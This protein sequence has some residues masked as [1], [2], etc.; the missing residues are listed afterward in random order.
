MFAASNVE[1]C[2]TMYNSNLDARTS[3]IIYRILQIHNDTYTFID[4]TSFLL[5]L[6]QGEHGNLDSPQNDSTRNK[7]EIILDSIVF[8]CFPVILVISYF[9]RIFTSESFDPQKGQNFFFIGPCNGL[10]SG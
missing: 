3:T 4:I 6:Q 5:I 8:L 9:I 7:E 10:F 1:H 2:T